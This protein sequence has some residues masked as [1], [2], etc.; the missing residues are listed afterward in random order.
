MQIFREARAEI[1][2]GDLGF[3]AQVKAGSGVDLG[4][5]VGLG[6]GVGAHQ[7]ISSSHLDVGFGVGARYAENED[8][9]PGISLGRT[10]GLGISGGLNKEETNV[11]ASVLTPVGTFGV[12]VGCTNK[13]CFYGCLTIDLC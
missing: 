6:L 5:G 7:K 8:R 4:K 9:G 10:L 1:Q 13:I 11:G 2:D 3:H 12:H